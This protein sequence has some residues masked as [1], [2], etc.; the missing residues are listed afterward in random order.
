MK[1]LLVIV[2][3]SVQASLALDE[4]LEMAQ[5]L[6]GSEIVLLSIAELP[7]PW[8]RRRLDEPKRT[9]IAERVI[10]LA[11]ARAEAVGVSARARRETG[12]VAEVTAGVARAER[13]DH[14]YMPEQDPTPVVARAL[15]TAI[16]LSAPSPA[17]RIFSL[18]H[19][20]VTVVANEGRGASH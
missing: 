13:C 19:V 4:A 1:R 18:A 8:Q 20:P 3:G 15:M 5:T 14:I 7:S 11:M 2:D 10:G 12:D 16:G 9:R 6:P 17:R